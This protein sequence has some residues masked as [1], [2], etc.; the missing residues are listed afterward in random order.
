MGRFISVLHVLV[1]LPNDC[2]QSTRIIA[3]IF[4]IRQLLLIGTF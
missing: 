3:I 2:I 1:E 4:I